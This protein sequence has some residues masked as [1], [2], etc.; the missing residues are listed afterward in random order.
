M[1]LF[2][3]LTLALVLPAATDFFE[4]GA[5]LVEDTIVANLEFVAYLRGRTSLTH[6]DKGIAQKKDF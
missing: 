3:A 1:P 6:N 4:G 2:L 5:F